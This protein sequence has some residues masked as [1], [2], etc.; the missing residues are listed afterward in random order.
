MIVCN[1]TISDYYNKIVSMP[2]NAKRMNR[3]PFHNIEHN[4]SVMKAN[5][6]SPLQSAL[7]TFIVFYSTTNQCLHRTQNSDF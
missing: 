4:H 7:M 1:I 6:N 5:T 2:E 3:N